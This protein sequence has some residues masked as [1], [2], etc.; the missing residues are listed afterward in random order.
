MAL[1]IPLEKRDVA[2]WRIQAVSFARMAR[3]FS[4]DQKLSACFAALALDASAN[5]K[6]AARQNL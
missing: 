2:H 6:K 3:K 1:S 4:A 5:A